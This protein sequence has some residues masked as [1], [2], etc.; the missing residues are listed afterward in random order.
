MSF[1]IMPRVFFVLC[2]AVLSVAGQWSGNYN[3][4]RVPRKLDPPGKCWIQSLDKANGPYTAIYPCTCT[5][6]KVS[7]DCSWLQQERVFNR[8]ED[9]S[10]KCAKTRNID[11]EPESLKAYGR[12]QPGAVTLC[13]CDPVAGNGDDGTDELLDQDSSSQLPDLPSSAETI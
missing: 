13:I 7:G 2:L 10:C 1:A 3:T 8:V 11:L 12:G 6:G 4:T 9:A 5:G